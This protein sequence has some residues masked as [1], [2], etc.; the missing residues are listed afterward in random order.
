MFTKVNLI[1]PDNY[2]EII[3][4]LLHVL[5]T[6]FEQKCVKINIHLDYGVD[7]YDAVGQV[8]HKLKDLN[9]AHFEI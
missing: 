2:F 7:L 8:V 1:P 9:L 5:K 3:G 6:P 4:D